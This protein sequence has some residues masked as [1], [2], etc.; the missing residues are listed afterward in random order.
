MIAT[1]PPLPPKCANDLQAAIRAFGQLVTVLD[2][3]GPRDIRARVRMLDAQELANCLEAYNCRLTVAAAD[4][5]TPP[6]KGLVFIVNS[7]R[8]GVMDGLE[9]RPS[10]LL[11][12]WVLRV[13]G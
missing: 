10:G 5:P 3:Q 7:V 13:K 4:F 11:V 9:V 8:R 6:Q 1:L 2:N 12:G